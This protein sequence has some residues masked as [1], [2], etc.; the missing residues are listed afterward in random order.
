MI[1]RDSMYLGS[2]HDVKNLNEKQ[3]Q[4]Y[5]YQSI[6]GSLHTLEILGEKEGLKF[7]HIHKDSKKIS[8]FTESLALWCK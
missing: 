8:L 7:T 5:S 4:F 3:Q 1:P 2:V 6:P